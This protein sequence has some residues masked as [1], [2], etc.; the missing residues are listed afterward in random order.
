MAD[1]AGAGSFAAIARHYDELM[2]SIPYSMWVAYYRLLLERQGVA[3]KSILD[4]CCGTGTLTQMLYAL[5]YEVCG[6]DRSP[7]MIERARG[8]AHARGLPIEYI[9]ADASD[10]SLGRSFGAACSFF[11]SLNYIADR[12][13]F[14]AAIH[15]VAQHIEPG[16]SFVFDLNTAYAFEAKLFNQRDTRNSSPVRYEWVGD[17]DPATRLIRVEMKFWVGGR[18]F[19]E[20]HLQRAHTDDEVR[21]SLASAGFT[22]VQCFHSYTLDPPR[23]RTD[24]V[25][26]AVLRART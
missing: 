4:V 8:K 7:E 24:R 1:R 17:Y 25:H 6:I 2:A 20:V 23:K 14:D 5:G 9:V 3:P 10:F 11:D 15:C 22:D 26:Y 19:E 16:G 18:S 21:A 13:R 12:E